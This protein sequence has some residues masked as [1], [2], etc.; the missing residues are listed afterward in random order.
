ME[1]GWGGGGGGGG[2]GLAPQKIESGFTV[3]IV[4]MSFV[5]VQDTQV[6]VMV[7]DSTL[8]APL[9]RKNFNS[10]GNE[11]REKQFSYS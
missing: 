2:G 6:R 8:T 10:S 5:M 11:Y 9:C 4:G 1:R 7:Q 3:P